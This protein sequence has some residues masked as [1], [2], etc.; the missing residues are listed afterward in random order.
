MIATGVMLGYAIQ[1]FAAIQIMF[2]NI[3]RSSKFAQTH[4]TYAELILRASMVLVTFAVAELVPNLGLLLTLIG[5]VCCVV[6][7]FVF[8]AV[9]ELIILNSDEGGIGMLRW[10]K[11][12]AILLIALA[13]FV[14]GGWFSLKQIIEDIVG[15]FN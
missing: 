13:G 3:S 1:F 4:P 14:F 6:L 2:S 10:T 5:S 11:N 12:I 9:S 15:K 8:P 7:S